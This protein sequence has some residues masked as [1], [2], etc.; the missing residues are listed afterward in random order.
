MV[1]LVISNLSINYGFLD[2]QWMVT[3]FHHLRCNFLSEATFKWVK[4]ANNVLSALAK[5]GKLCGL[6]RRNFIILYGLCPVDL[7]ELCKTFSGLRL[8]ARV[9]IMRPRSRWRGFTRGWKFQITIHN[10]K[11]VIK[12][13]KRRKSITSDVDENLVQSYVVSTRPR[14][15]YQ[16]APGPSHGIN[17]PYV[18][19]STRPNNKHLMLYRYQLAPLHGINL[20]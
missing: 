12:R 11:S 13:W 6:V 9:T 15:W 1:C 2:P 10:V 4:I 17:L 3:T 19:V 16:L 14:F 18:M 20:P 8:L 5:N 7:M